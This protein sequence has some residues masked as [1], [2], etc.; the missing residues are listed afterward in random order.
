MT[1]LTEAPQHPVFRDW[2]E[3]AQ[4]SSQTVV[5]EN[6]ADR[7]STAWKG[8][9]WRT[10]CGDTITT[11]QRV[12]LQEDFKAPLRRIPASVSP[13]H[14]EIAYNLWCRAQGLDDLGTAQIGLV[15]DNNTGS[16]G[17]YTAGSIA[18][19]IKISTVS[20]RMFISTKGHLGLCPPTSGMIFPDKDRIFV[21]PGGKTP[22]VLRNVGM[23]HV[24]GLGMQRCH[25]LIGD[26]YLDGFMDGE[27][28]GNF[29][30]QTVYIV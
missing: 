14:E 22:L 29:E 12:L 8:R 26:C 10:L 13:G 23:R 27:G 15:N 2:H 25:E 17:G 11:P 18:N 21:L 24:P 30:K 9:F 20:R 4:K 6:D 16:I 7:D 3:F 5:R 19:A 28:M 1:Y